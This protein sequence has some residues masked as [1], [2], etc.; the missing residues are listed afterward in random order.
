FY[1]QHKICQSDETNTMRSLF[2]LSLIPPNDRDP[3]RFRR[4]TPQGEEFNGM[5]FARF[6]RKYPQLIRRLHSGM[7]RETRRD[8][9]RQFRCERLED[10]VQFLADNQHLPGLYLDVASPPGQPWQ[11]RQDRLLEPPDRFPQ[12]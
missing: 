7:H 2:E 10:V 3:E 11:P 9:E 12:L 1:T 5:E 6:C 4:R 8:Y